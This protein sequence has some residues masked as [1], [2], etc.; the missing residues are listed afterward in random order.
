[1]A[2]SLAIFLESEVA[3]QVVSNTHHSQMANRKPASSPATRRTRLRLESL[4]VRVIDLRS[5]GAPPPP[6]LLPN[7][8]ELPDFALYLDRLI[9]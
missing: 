9:V 8:C 2:E 5:T 4:P 1:M 3:E 7:R 6:N